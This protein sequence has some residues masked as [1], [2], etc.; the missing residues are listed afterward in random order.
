MNRPKK[1]STEWRQELA[2]LLVDGELPEDARREFLRGLDC[3]PDGW[4]RLALTFLEAQAW[5]RSMGELLAPERDATTSQSEEEIRPPRPVAR[6]KGTASSALPR[7]TKR[8]IFEVAAL[9]AVFMVA[10]TLGGWLG[11]GLG[12]KPTPSGDHRMDLAV[13]SPV[14]PG[15][16]GAPALAEDNAAARS[17]SPQPVV[18]PWR[19][20]S[21]PLGV[22]PDGAMT[23][24]D[25][26]VLDP[27]NPVEVS[28]TPPG[29]YLPLPQFVNSLRQSGHA[30][31][32]QREYVPVDLPDGSRTVFPVDRLQIK[33]VGNR[34][35]Q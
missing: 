19:L 34:G 1:M 21:V 22:G 26:P 31:E 35:Y 25:L 16:P 28:K 9:A 2:D 24:V 10:L 30:V 6:A 11:G 32:H 7:G 15:Q 5:H 12:R 13:Q 17:V 8:W 3:S 27:E 18:S 23:M 29:P 14:S 20:V 4:R 33:F